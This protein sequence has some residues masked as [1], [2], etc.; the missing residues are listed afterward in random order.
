MNMLA[1]VGC[2]SIVVAR[3]S[4]AEKVYSVDVNPLAVRFML[5]NVRLNRVFG[6]VIPVLCDMKEVVFER[7]VQGCRQGS[8]A[9]A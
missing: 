3:F 1:G 5:E 2:F 4:R 7:L 6:R 8:H 9:S